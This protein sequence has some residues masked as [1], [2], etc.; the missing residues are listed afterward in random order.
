MP[1]SSETYGRKVFTR[2]ALIG[3]VAGALAGCSA[4]SVRLADLSNP[5]QGQPAPDVTGSLGPAPT[6]RVDSQALPPPGAPVSAG[7]GT[8]SA[9]GQPYGGS[10]SYGGP[11]SYAAQNAPQPL[12]GTPN[13]GAQAS[14]ARGVSHVV[15]PGETLGSVARRYNVPADQLATANHIAPGMTVRTG[16]ALVIPPAAASTY[17]SA[18]VP[19]STAVA[20]AQKPVAKPAA[21]P[22]ETAAKEAPP[23]AK[24]EMAKTDAPKGDDG[25]GGTRVATAAKPENTG[26][27]A[28][29]KTMAD[30]SASADAGSD[31]DNGPRTG[32]GPQFRAPVRG[33]VIASFGPKPGGARND[34]V[35]FAVPEGTAVRAAEDGEVAYAGNE[36]KG[37]GNLV[38]IKHSNGYVTAYAHNS[39]LDVKRGDTVR[40]GQIIAKAG[41]S[42]NVTTP[43]LHFEIRKGSQPVDPGSYVA[44]L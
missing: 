13:Y 12:Y 11:A 1:S 21:K 39:E 20:T 16:Q 26:E 15:E 36:L 41:Q 27:A 44:G 9:S 2:L 8:Q 25:K 37:Y 14:A 7:Y 4:D 30:G 31:A 33:R 38:L 43:Q 34:G 23:A 17:A 35:N 3:T 10:Q 5:G 18:G 6:G 29:K 42:G 28:A 24:P 40:R 19:S 22:A 32:S